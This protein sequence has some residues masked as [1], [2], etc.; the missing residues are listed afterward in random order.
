MLG[1]VANWISSGTPACLRR[2]WSSAHS[3]GKYRRQAIGR[4]AP[5]VLTDRLTATRR[6]PAYPP[7][8]NIA[9][10]RPPNA[11]LS[12]GNRCHPRS[13]PA[14]A[15][16]DTWPSTHSYALQP[17]LLHRP[18]VRPPLRGAVTD[19]SAAHCLVPDG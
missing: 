7:A 19:A 14:R 3:C 4:L 9:A 12:L 6:F 15:L 16:F 1:F 18:T 2:V 10:P 11:F 17:T 13:K 8:H 5:F